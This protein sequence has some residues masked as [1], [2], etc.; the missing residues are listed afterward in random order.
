MTT[1]LCFLNPYTRLGGTELVYNLLAECHRGE[2]HEGL[3]P[4]SPGDVGPLITAM[5]IAMV[6]K[7]LL[8]V[9]TFG[10]K[11]PAGIFIPTLGVGACFGRIVGLVV[12]CWRKTPTSAIFSV[13]RGD[14]IA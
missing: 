2:S 4:T 12:Q 5:G 1:L 13:C 7:G 8:M 6:V 3:C 11:V 9:V 10:I 14:E